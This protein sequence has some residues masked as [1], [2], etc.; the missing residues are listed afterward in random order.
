MEPEVSSSYWQKSLMMSLKDKDF[1]K[2]KQG[3]ERLKDNFITE[4]NID[5]ELD[6][7]K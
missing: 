2:W 6:G 7:G 1:Y 3:C 5:N 4:N